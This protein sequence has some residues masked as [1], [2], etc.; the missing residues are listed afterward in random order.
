MSMPKGKIEDLYCTAIAMKEKKKQIYEDAMKICPDQVGIETFRLLRDAEA[1]H[2]SSLEAAFAQVQTGGGS[3][4]VCSLRELEGEDTKGFL[5]KVAKEHGRMPRACLDDVAAIAMGMALENESIHYLT[6]RLKEG[7]SGGE[8]TLLEKLI[9][10]ERGHY[11]MLADLKF[12]YEDTENW[13]LEK[14][15]YRLDGAGAGT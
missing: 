9:Q 12:Y 3:A 10:E 2:V 8:K 5:R 13:L 15:G 14:G 4:P 6:E 1:D 11:I 7:P